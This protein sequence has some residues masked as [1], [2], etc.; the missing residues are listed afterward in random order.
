MTCPT[1]RQNRRGSVFIL[2]TQ[3]LDVEKKELSKN[4]LRWSA[5]RIQNAKH[6]V[7]R[8]NADGLQ[9]PL[10]QRP[11]IAVALKNNAWKSKTVTWRR[12]NKLWYRYVHNIN[13]VND[14]ISN[15]KGEKTSITVSIARLGGGTKSVTGKPARSVFIFNIAVAD[16]AMA[17]ELELMVFHIIWYVVVMSVSWKE[18]HKIDGSCGQYTHEHYTYSAVQSL[19]QRGTHRTRLAQEL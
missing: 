17:N 16:F 8:L 14:K 18:F 7:L 1:D 4:K 19:H 10:R 3:D 5:E 12:R 15:S 6:W 11:D 13:N 2:G 9:K